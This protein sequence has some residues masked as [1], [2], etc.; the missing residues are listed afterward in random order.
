M[1]TYHRKKYVPP[2]FMDSRRMGGGRG[3]LVGGLGGCGCSW[4]VRRLTL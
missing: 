2:A 3:E 4:I 1:C